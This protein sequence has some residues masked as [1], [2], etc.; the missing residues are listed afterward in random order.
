MVNFDDLLYRTPS[1]PVPTNA[2]GLQTLMCVT[3]LV[4]CCESEGLGDWY[5]PDG[6]KV[7]F[8]TGSSV[9]FQSNRAQN[10]EV[11][12][13]QLNGSVRLWRRWT[14]LER[15]LFHCELPDAHNTIQTLYVNICES[16]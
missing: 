6:T 8:D 1:D 13:Q 11:I 5:Y 15:G 9:T 14:P 4:T 3:E 12:G 10:E 16:N 2:N 7:G